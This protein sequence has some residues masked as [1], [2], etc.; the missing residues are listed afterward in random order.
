MLT[1]LTA[2][3]LHV[4]YSCMFVPCRDVAA[5]TLLKGSGALVWGAA[6]VLNVLFAAMP[7]M[8]IFGDHQLTL[9]FVFAGVGLGCFFG[10]IGFNLALAPE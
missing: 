8:L 7:S 3:S 2:L 10:P 1:W 5:F 6:D 4:P 9:G